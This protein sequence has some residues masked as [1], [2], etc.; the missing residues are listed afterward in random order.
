MDGTSGVLFVGYFSFLRLLAAITFCCLLAFLPWVVNPANLTYMGF[1]FTTGIGRVWLFACDI[2]IVFLAL[3]LFPMLL[4]AVVRRPAVEVTADH[5]RVW[6]Y[7]WKSCPRSVFAAS[8]KRKSGNLLAKQKDGTKFVVPLWA[9]Q[10][11]SDLSTFLL[12]PVTT[13]SD[14]SSKS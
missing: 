12:A 4:G 3:G 8:V 7:K 6:R 1:L 13:N 9:L 2:I 14:L 10:N 5:T 11:A